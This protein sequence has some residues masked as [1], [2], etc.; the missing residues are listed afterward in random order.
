MGLQE[1]H[2]GVL[3]LTLSDFFSLVFFFIFL[4]FFWSFL[5]LADAGTMKVFSLATWFVFGL[6]SRQ[7]L[8]LPNESA[9]VAAVEAKDADPMTFDA[10]SEIEQS[11]VEADDAD[12]EEDDADAEED[13]A[14]AEED[15]ADAEEDD[16]DAE[17]DDADNNKS[18]RQA[19]WQQ[20]YMAWK[21]GRPVWPVCYTKWSWRKTTHCLKQEKNTKCSVRGEN[22]GLN[23]G[24][25][26]S[27][28]WKGS[29][30]RQVECDSYKYCYIYR[31]DKNL[32]CSTNGD[33]KSR[34]TECA[35]NKAEC[36]WRTYGGK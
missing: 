23:Y 4:F 6:C 22:P 20:K 9:A 24:C 1:S 13:D 33:V 16:A 10:D 18:S 12:A 29:C 31:N 36:G 2:R 3:I 32:K 19:S 30:W 21:L 11:I 28:I 8:G 15:D 26:E 34:A 14:D 25:L 35:D 7:L 5:H 17:E 27:G